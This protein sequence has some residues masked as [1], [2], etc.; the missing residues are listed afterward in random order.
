MNLLHLSDNEY[1]KN[2]LKRRIGQSGGYMERE[3]EQ[4]SAY[5]LQE[6][7]ASSNTEISYKRDLKKLELY[8]KGQDI[9][10]VEEVTETWLN[11]YVLYLEKSQSAVSSISRNIASIKSFFH[12]L[13]YKEIIR[14]DP[15][16]NLKAPKV[17]RKLP[18]ILTVEE[19]N[20]LLEQPSK[21][22]KKGI[23][24]RAMLELLY[25]TGIR[26]SELLRLTMMDINMQLGF[27]VLRQGEKER[28][29]SFHKKAKQ[30]LE[31]YLK[32][33]RTELLKGRE[34]DYFFINC[35][36]EAM[37]RQGF[38]KLMKQYGNQAG[39]KKEIT[40][41]TLRHSFAAHLIENGTNIHVVQQMMGHSD[42]QTTQMYL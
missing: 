28:I 29:V 2:G 14:N 38:W 11:A 41:H 32:H 1:K 12:Y 27:C 25:A 31:E 6:K 20:Y 9:Q 23:R 7:H 42:I 21:E 3:I 33:A 22:N 8:L 26:V 40:P 19:V 13:Y 4:F 15:S 24:D 36:G 10:K 5:L 35:S 37:S 39:I 34:S 17:E 16:W 18:E 30:A